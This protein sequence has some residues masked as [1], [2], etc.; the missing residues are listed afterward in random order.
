MHPPAHPSA[1]L[2]PLSRY[3]PLC[4]VTPQTQG[5][6]CGSHVSHSKCHR[7]L[8]LLWGLP[9]RAC[10]RL[11]SPCASLLLG[12]RCAGHRLCRCCPSATVRAHHAETPGLCTAPFHC[13]RAP[14]YTLTYTHT[15]TNT[16]TR[17]GSTAEAE[18]A[19]DALVGVG[20]G[21]DTSGGMTDAAPR[22]RA[23]PSRCQLRTAVP[24]RRPW[25][26]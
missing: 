22:V 5:L 24:L 4:T 9:H 2:T 8:R 3:L 14:V 10:P 23:Q 6:A 25:P 21:V 12:G 17:A 1:S 15:P 26:R 18:G 20:V 13:S 16:H 11:Y 19:A 7:L